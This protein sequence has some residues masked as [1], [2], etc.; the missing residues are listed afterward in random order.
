M[1][2]SKHVYVGEW[3]NPWHF[4][5]VMNFTN[6]TV[7]IALRAGAAGVQEEQSKT[8]FIQHYES[9]RKMFPKQWL[10]EYEVREGWD[11]L[12]AFLGEDVPGIQFPHRNDHAEYQ[13]VGRCYLPK[14]SL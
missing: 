4:G 9:V 10:L 13:H 2:H 1:Y 5:K 7:T 11:S 12:C 3:F 14:S 8:Q 6:M